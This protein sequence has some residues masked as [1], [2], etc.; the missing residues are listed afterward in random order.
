VFAECND[1]LVK[2]LYYRDAK[3]QEMY[4]WVIKSKS[5]KPI[6]MNGY[7]LYTKSGKMMKDNYLKLKISPY[8]KRTFD[9][10]LVGLNLDLAGKPWVSC[11]YTNLTDRVIDKFK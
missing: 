8:G 1:E 9:H 5:D 4:R 11:K 2:E 3:G 6:T 10:Y 7:G